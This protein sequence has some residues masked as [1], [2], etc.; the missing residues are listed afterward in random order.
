MLTHWLGAQAW[1][2][3]TLRSYGAALRGMYR[4]AHSEGRIAEDPA[5]GLPAVLVGRGLPRPAPEAVWRA[6]VGR[7]PARVALMLRCAA[8]AGLRRGEIARLCGADVSRAPD[9]PVLLVHGKGRRDR[10]VPISDGLAAALTGAGPGWVFPSQTGGHVSARWVGKLCSDALGDGF[11]L[12]SLRHRF[13]T[14]AY[15]GSRDLR[16]VQELLGHSTPVITQRYVQVSGAALRAA[17]MTA[18]S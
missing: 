7:A 2:P 16:A 15:R 13:G 14:V 8:Q 1:R 17:M 6:A 9:G 4:W 10:V 3:E 11:T 5:A 12:H 18:A